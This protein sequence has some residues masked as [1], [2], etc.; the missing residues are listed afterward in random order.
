[1][2]IKIGITIGDI[3]SIA[4]EVIIKMLSDERIYEFCQPIIYGSTKVLSYYKKAF[5]L[6]KFRYTHLKDW[7]MLMGKQSFVVNCI[8]EQPQI[9]MG[10]CTAEAGKYALDSLDKAL[11][12]W[13]EGHLDAI[14]TA[15][16]NKELVNQ[17]TD[18][19]FKGHT[20][21]ISAYTGAENSL[22]FLCSEKLKVG[23][24]T[25]HIALKDVA[26]KLSKKSLIDKLLLMNNSLKNDFGIPK[27]KIAVLGLNPH[28]GDNNLIGTEE[29]DII[30]PAIID[31][32]SR[33]I[34]AFGSYPAD[35]FFCTDAFTK[36]DAVLAMY[37][38]QGLIPFKSIAFNE[39]VNFTAGLNLVRT[40]PDH[41]TAYDICGKGIASE[42]SMRQALFTAIDIVRN[43]KGF[44]DTEN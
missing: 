4:P 21:Y 13:K 35:G 38:D 44:E 41:G 28:A 37:H 24:A 22:M 1:M 31:A 20:E 11:N 39:G 33:G 30:I 18:F 3:N 34:Y 7:G 23:L 9:A 15:P 10:Q 42:K 6:H 12:D 17:H 43:R 2:Q 32:N 27:P 19:D 5:N 25:N 36:F 40:S 16:I 8:D 29:K 26:N 14:L